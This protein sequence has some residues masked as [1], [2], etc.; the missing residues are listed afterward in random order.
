MGNFPILIAYWSECGIFKQNRD[1]PD[2]I[3]MVGQ[4]VRDFSFFIIFLLEEVVTSKQERRLRMKV[5]L[6]TKFGR[7]IF[8]KN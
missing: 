8:W 2:E 4:S 7:G 1:N 3:E 6:I 5:R